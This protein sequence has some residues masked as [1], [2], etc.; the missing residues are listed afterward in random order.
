VRRAVDELPTI[1]YRPGF[2][3][4]QQNLRPGFFAP[5]PWPGFAYTV[6]RAAGCDASFRFSVS[7]NELW[8][9]WCALQTPIYSPDIDSWGCAIRGS[10]GSSDSTTCTV[11]AQ[12]GARATYPLWKCTACGVF[13]SDGGVCACDQNACSANMTATQVLNLAYSVSGTTEILSGPDS[14]C[15]DCTVRLERQLIN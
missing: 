12:S 11:M 2:W 1:P 14:S 8:Q 10:G 3:E 7:T 15:G 9:N 5:D 6:V 13:S 4:Q